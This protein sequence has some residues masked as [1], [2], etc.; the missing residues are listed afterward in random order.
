MMI[1]MVGESI[2]TNNDRGLHLLK[3]VLAKYI[4]LYVFNNAGFGYGG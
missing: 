1:F 2:A 3:Q 4:V